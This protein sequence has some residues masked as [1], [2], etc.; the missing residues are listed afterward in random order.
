MEKVLQDIKDFNIDSLSGILRKNRFSDIIH[1]T[2]FV[3]D[4]KISETETKKFEVFI[5]VAKR[6]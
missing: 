3:I 6:N 4:R 1:K 5:I 2:C